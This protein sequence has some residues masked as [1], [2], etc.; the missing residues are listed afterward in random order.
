MNLLMLINAYPWRVITF[1]T[2]DLKQKNF[3]VNET[4]Y[5]RGTLTCTPLPPRYKDEI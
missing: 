5:S 4:H 2:I 1:A 3:K